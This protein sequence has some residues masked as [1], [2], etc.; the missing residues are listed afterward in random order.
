MQED[1]L[2]NLHKREENQQE[3]YAFFSLLDRMKLIARWSLMRSTKRENLAE[4]SYDVAV[5]AHFLAVLRQEQFSYLPQVSLE[6]V[7]LYALY[8]DAPEVLTGDLPTPVKY[9][10]EDLRN[11]FSQ[12]EERATEKLL[13]TLPS[14]L[15]V[16]YKD[17][18]SLGQ[19]PDVYAFV[20]AADRLS[21]YLKCCKELQM[22]NQEFTLAKEQCYQ[23][24]QK[25]S[26]PEVSYFLEHCLQAYLLPLDASF[27]SENRKDA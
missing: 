4:H 25:S 10:S 17:V 1:V 27:S 19:N 9:Y 12:V 16:L 23:D 21:A 7:L 15:Q 13:A 26:L 5:L 20:K 24:L 6:K 8:H 11:A 22:G 3:Q 14:P 18:F 2:K